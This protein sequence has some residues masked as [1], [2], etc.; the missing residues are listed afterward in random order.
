[1]N[2]LLPPSTQKEAV[3]LGDL[4]LG[5]LHE[6]LQ[7][8][9]LLTE[10]SINYKREDGLYRRIPVKHD[11]TENQFNTLLDDNPFVIVRLGEQDDLH[12]NDKKICGDS[13]IRSQEQEYVDVLVKEDL[14]QTDEPVGVDPDARCNSQGLSFDEDPGKDI[15]YFDNVLTPPFFS[16][17]GLS[18]ST[19]VDQVPEKVKLLKRDSKRPLFGYGAH[20]SLQALLVEQPTCSQSSLRTSLQTAV[21]LEWATLPLYLTSL[22]TIKSGANSEGEIRVFNVSLQEMIHFG[23][24]NNLL[25]SV[26]GIPII[27]ASTAPSYPTKGLPGGVL[28]HLPISLKKLSIDHV[29]S[30]FMGVEIPRNSSAVYP[31]IINDLYTIGAFY[32]EI[33]SCMKYLGNQIFANASLDK[34][35]VFDWLPSRGVLYQVDNLT[36]AEMAINEII[37][38]GEGT[39]PVDPVDALTNQYAHFYKFEE[40]VCQKGLIPVGN[41]RYAYQGNPVP[42]NATG[43]YN[44]VDNPNKNTIP[45]N[46]ECYNAT[47]EFNV[48]YVT[49]M[50]MLEETFT[51]NPSLIGNAVSYMKYVIPPAAQYVVKL[52]LQPGSPYNCGPVWDLDWD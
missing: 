15:P 40:I 26:G 48:K 5:I 28:Q 45:P 17:F 21:E 47:R 1:M 23:Q 36:V 34:Q 29:Y 4:R 46:T 42:F 25:I 51:G 14:H 10:N 11:I 7:C 38:Q 50:K 31:P 52:P 49:L 27:N 44:M 13:I 37:D 9:E 8:V 30:T 6:S 24:A 12:S 2:D 33:L 20:K 35:V 39:S 22:Y 19:T 16:R 41:M 18:S 3:D 43:V 32:N